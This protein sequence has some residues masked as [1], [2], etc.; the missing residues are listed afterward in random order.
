MK[1]AV[2]YSPGEMPQYVDF[3]DPVVKNDDEV[4]EVSDGKRVV[5]RI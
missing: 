2:M 4:L 5:V 1:A 3:P